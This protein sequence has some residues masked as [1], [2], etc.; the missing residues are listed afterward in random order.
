M[1]KNLKSAKLKLE[2][3]FLEC[4]RYIE[5]N[6]VRARLVK[7]AG[8]YPHSSYRHYAYG[9]EDLLVEVDPYYVDLGR[10][11]E[12]RQKEY[13]EFVKLDGPYDPIVDASLMEEHF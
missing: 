13:R 7:D 10:D 3:Y 2:S 8:D 4:G 1:L 11:P 12:E 9:E 5:R 6:P